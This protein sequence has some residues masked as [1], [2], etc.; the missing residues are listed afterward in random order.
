ME[1][2][3]PNISA[4][5]FCLR[6]G[7][8]KHISTG[9]EVSPSGISF[10]NLGAV[11]ASSLPDLLHRSPLY[12]MKSRAGCGRVELPGS[13]LWWRRNISLTFSSLRSAPSWGDFGDVLQ[14][15]ASLLPALSCGR[16]LVPCLGSTRGS[17][18]CLVAFVAL[19]G[20]DVLL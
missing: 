20:L 16:S 8:G 18:R 12:G 4:S 10:S 5:T 1:L 2:T 13:S 15:A 6:Q 11:A 19:A 9:A 3:C 14:G 17:R 7:L